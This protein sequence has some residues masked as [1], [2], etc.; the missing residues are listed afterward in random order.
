[1]GVKLDE[2]PRTFDMLP[3]KTCVKAKE[4]GLASFWL[5][6]L[7]SVMKP[8][9]PLKPPLHRDVSAPAAVTSKR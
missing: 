2:Q 1:M 4:R 9:W 3:I 6:S 7:E 8:V 5:L